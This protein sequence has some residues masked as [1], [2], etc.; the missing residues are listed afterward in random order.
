VRFRCSAATVSPERQQ[1]EGTSPTTIH[2][3]NPEQ[4]NLPLVFGRPLNSAGAGFFRFMS[5]KIKIIIIAVLVLF[6]ALA[7]RNVPERTPAQPDRA[8]KAIFQEENMGGES[9]DIS[10]GEETVNPT[11]ISFTATTESTVYGLMADARAQGKISFTEKNYTG[12]GKLIDSINGIRSNGEKT[13]IYYVNGVKANV[14]V[15]N[16]KLKPGDVVSWKYEKLL[17]Y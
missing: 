16:Y 14:G 7:G 6:V 8:S 10:A 13:W 12:M 11:E 4:D 17:A 1:A 3:R 5:K 2:F 15:S 9:K